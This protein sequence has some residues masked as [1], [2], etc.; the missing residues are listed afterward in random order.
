VNREPPSLHAPYPVTGDDHVMQARRAYLSRG[1]RLA[2]GAMHPGQPPLRHD[3]RLRDVLQI[4]DGED[5]IRVAVAMHR[6]DT[7]SAAGPPQPVDAETGNLETRSRACGRLRDVV[8]VSP[9]RNFFLFV[10]LSASAFSK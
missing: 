3:L 5:V 8:N 10:M 7:R 4:H 2:A 9:D 1:V 6:P